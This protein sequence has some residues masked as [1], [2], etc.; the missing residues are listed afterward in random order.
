MF[1]FCSNNCNK[2]KGQEWLSW[3]SMHT[4]KHQKVFCFCFSILLIGQQT[5]TQQPK[6]VL[7]VFIRNCAL[8][9]QSSLGKVT[10]ICWPC[11]VLLDAVFIQDVQMN[12][13]HFN[14]WSKSPVVIIKTNHLTRQI[15]PM[16]KQK[17]W[18]SK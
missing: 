2:W 9:V 6:V 7:Q 13:E 5:K 17:V 16:Q 3:E 12:A 4:N 11:L 18:P 1:L 8:S 10:Q 14:L 15:F